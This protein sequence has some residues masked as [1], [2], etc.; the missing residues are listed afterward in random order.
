MTRE[1]KAIL[2]DLD[3][4][5]TD[6]QAGLG[7]AHDFL[8]SELC[9]YI[10][11]RGAEIGENKIRATLEKLDNQMNRKRKYDRDE[12]WPE[13]FRRL[14]VQVK[15]PSSR[16]KKLTKIYWGVHAKGSPPYPEAREVLSEL[17]KRGYKLGL[18]TDTDGKKGLKRRRLRRMELL[19]FFG[20][21]VIGGDDTP[22]PKPSPEPF[23]LAARKLRARPS[24]CLMVGDKPF[25][26]IR[27]AKAAG[28]KTVL[29]KKREWDAKDRPDFT[30]G[31]LSEILHVVENL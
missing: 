19:E 7:A 10:K 27:G 4:T 5:L 18:V 13:L 26:D 6:A 12:W 2:F 17:K 29:L 25:T 15:L 20:A 11:S 16:K 21:V 22:R 31:A 30:V 1:I 3:E 14:H 9:K 24:E 28:M 8:A 23:L